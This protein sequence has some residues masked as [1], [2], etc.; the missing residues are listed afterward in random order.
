MALGMPCELVVLAPS[1]A[2]F[3]SSNGIPSVEVKIVEQMQF[4]LCLFVSLALGGIP[5]SG[6]SRKLLHSSL[7]HQGFRLARA[8][9]TG[10]V[11]FWHS[12]S[13]NPHRSLRYHL[14][15]LLESCAIRSSNFSLAK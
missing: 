6:P 2:G 4:L 9:R 14:V 12:V 5:Y 1:T 3:I 11:W 13:Y 8:Y 15:S 10:S 7:Y